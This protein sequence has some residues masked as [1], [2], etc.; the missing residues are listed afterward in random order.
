MPEPWSSRTHPRLGL[1]RVWDVPLRTLFGQVSLWMFFVY[2]SIGLFGVEPIYK[3]IRSAHWFFR[4][5]AY[6]AIVLAMEWATGWVVR[7]LSGY[8]IWYYDDPLSFSLR[9]TSL[10]IGP[11]WFVIGLAAENFLAF[12]TKYNEKKARP[13]E[14]ETGSPA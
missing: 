13:R 1:D 4:G 5:L 2:A 8:E 14:L 12:V 11:L 6:M 3:R 7:A 9:Y 10:A